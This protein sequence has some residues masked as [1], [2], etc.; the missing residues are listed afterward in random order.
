[1]DES[2]T[3]ALRGE[4]RAA[5]PEEPDLFDFG[6]GRRRQLAAAKPSPA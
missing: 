1:V 4:L 5:R 6:E 3:D 2:A